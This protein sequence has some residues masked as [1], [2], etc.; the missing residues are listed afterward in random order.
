MER[1]GNIYATRRARWWHTRDPMV[2][3]ATPA[4]SSR[5]YMSTLRLQE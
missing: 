1:L 3:V 4:M 5:G 2:A